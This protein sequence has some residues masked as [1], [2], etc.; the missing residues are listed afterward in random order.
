MGKVWSDFKVGRQ[1]TT[2]NVKQLVAYVPHMSMRV[3]RLY[4]MSLLSIKMRFNDIQICY[5]YFWDVWSSNDQ[6]RPRHLKDS[7]KTLNVCLDGA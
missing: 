5:M 1:G 7:L 3:Y 6:E 2:Q 4:F